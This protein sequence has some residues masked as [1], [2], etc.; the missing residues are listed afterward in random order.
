MVRFLFTGS[1]LRCGGGG[2]G[3]GGCC[4]C[5]GVAAGGGSFYKLKKEVIRVPRRGLETP[6][7][8]C[9]SLCFFVRACSDP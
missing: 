1:W 7:V 3:G 6:T 4:C 2:G 8:L 9:V 5:G